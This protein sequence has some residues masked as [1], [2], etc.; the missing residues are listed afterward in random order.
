M[1][2]EEK[3]FSLELQRKAYKSRGGEWGWKLK[4]IP[5][6]IEECK[7]L[8]YGVLGGQIQFLFPDGTCELYWL[9]ADPQAKSAEETWRDYSRRSCEEFLILFNELVKNTDFEKEGIEAFDFLKSKKTEGS[10]ILDYMFFLI[11]PVSYKR[12]IDRGYGN[13]LITDDPAQLEDPSKPVS[14]A[15][16]KIKHQ[17]YHR[18][19]IKW[20]LWHYI[21]S[22]F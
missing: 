17:A 15:S 6:V 8:N 4:D 2:K 13:L 14:F 21:K 20:S 12:Y 10:N 19:W 11:Y 22:F 18:G 16:A 3:A 7:A 5:L 1:K 9:R